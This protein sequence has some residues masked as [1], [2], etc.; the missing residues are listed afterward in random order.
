MN[1]IV[2]ILYYCFS[3]ESD[4]ELIDNAEVATFF[5]F[6][7]FMT[8]CFETFHEPYNNAYSGG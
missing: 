4:K 8:N 7:E 1:E 6:T 5:C 3:N 2:A